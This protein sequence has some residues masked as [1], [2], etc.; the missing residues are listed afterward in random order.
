MCFINLEIGE[1]LKKT[2]K[3]AKDLGF[4]LIQIYE[5]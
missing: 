5:L 3:K 2:T 4:F 1:H